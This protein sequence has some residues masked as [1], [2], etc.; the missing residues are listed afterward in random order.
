MSGLFEEQESQ[1]KWIFLNLT[2]FPNKSKMTKEKN[3]NLSCSNFLGSHAIAVKWY[4]KKRLPH[5]VFRK[6]AFLCPKFIHLPCCCGVV[7]SRGALAMHGLNFWL[8]F[9]SLWYLYYERL[10][11]KLFR[12]STKPDQIPTSLGKGVKIEVC[13]MAKWKNPF[14]HDK[15]CMWN[16]FRV[17]PTRPPW[18]FFD[19]LIFYLQR[20]P[21]AVHL[22]FPRFY[23]Y[24][25]R[26]VA[27]PL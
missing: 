19:F 9:L 6:L 11:N 14:F 15:L 10:F 27:Y 2:N 13:S 22:T 7:L 12:S 26:K 25:F 1:S 16:V 20:R 17:P 4:R 23:P 21:D 5:K 18:K 3:R 8:F 24:P